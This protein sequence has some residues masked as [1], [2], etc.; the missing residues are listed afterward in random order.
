VIPVPI[1]ESLKVPGN[2]EITEELPARNNLI[3][4]VQDFSLTFSTMYEITNR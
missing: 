1:R 3:S 4:D 2:P